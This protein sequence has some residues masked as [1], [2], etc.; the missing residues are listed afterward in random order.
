MI[1]NNPI[2]NG[3]AFDKPDC[4]QA[5]LPSGGRPDCCKAGRDRS[6]KLTHPSPLQGGDNALL[7]NFIY[8]LSGL[9]NL[10][11]ILSLHK[12]FIDSNTNN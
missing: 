1:N 2:E 11:I 3:K 5:G 10:L 12:L 7:G 9:N 4:R 8:T 6:E